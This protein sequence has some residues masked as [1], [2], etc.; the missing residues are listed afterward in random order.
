MEWLVNQPVK[1]GFVGSTTGLSSFPDLAILKDGTLIVLAPTY[2]EVGNKLYTIT[3]TPT[4]TG[5]YTVFIQ[6]L[7]QATVN[8]VTK[9]SQAML[10]ELLDE[11]LGS[12]NWNKTTGVLTLLKQ[13]GGTLAVYDVVDNQTTASRERTA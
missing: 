5:I 1:L 8:V 10:S 11:A 13:T 7:V 12:W 6:G 9:T 2:A 3:F 4:S